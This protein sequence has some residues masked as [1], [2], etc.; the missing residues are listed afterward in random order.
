MKEPDKMMLSQYINL[1]FKENKDIFKYIY[2]QGAKYIVTSAKGVIDKQKYLKKRKK[3]PKSLLSKYETLFS[4]ILG[5]YKGKRLGLEIDTNTIPKHAR[6]S[7]VLKEHEAV[8]L[9]KNQKFS[10]DRSSK[11]YLSYKMGFFHIH[12][13]K[14][15]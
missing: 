15:I 5:T 8:F 3:Q 13:S 10:Q 7:L 4:S 2:I 14:E 11:T 1:L 12:N 6:L 9:K